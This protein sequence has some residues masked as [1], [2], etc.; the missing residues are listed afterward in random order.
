AH[1]VVT[2]VADQPPRKYR[3]TFDRGDAVALL[4]GFDKRQ[5]IG[6]RVLFDHFAVAVHAHVMAEHL[7][8]RARRQANDRIAS[9]LFAAVHRLEQIRIRAAGKLEVSTEWGVEIRENI[10][11][12][13]NAVEI[14]CRQIGETSGIHGDI[15]E[16]KRFKTDDATT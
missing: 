14:L 2:E 4:E 7:D 5:R 11:K 13:W 12:D 9:P 1:G 3:Q 15:L 16:E 6:L 10:A 8:Q